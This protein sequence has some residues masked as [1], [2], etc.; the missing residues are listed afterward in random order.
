MHYHVIVLFIGLLKKLVDL[1][2]QLTLLLC[3]ILALMKESTSALSLEE[4]KKKHQ[5][6]CG[7]SSFTETVFNKNLT[8]GKLEGSVKVCLIPLE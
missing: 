8:E 2:I 5:V 7:T 6:L 4:F 1:H 3:R